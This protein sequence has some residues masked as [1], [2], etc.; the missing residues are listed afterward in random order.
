MLQNLFQRHGANLKVSANSPKVS[1]AGD[2]KILRTEGQAT[3]S[4]LVVASQ[5][6]S[7]ATNFSSLLEL[8]QGRAVQF[9]KNI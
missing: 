6:R 1:N 2:E 8:S 9:E 4:D 3:L 7:Q 5:N